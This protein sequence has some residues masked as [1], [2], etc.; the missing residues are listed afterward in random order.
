M[1]FKTQVLGRA[2]LTAKLDALVPNATKYAA[3]VK[4][5]IAETVADK[6]REVAPRGATL[7]Y[8][9]AIAGDFIKN[10]PAQKAIGIRD[11]K[12]PDAAGIFAPFQWNWLEFGT[13]PHNT[14]KG[15]G[16][17]A[18]QK[19]TRA[20]GAQIHPGTKAQPH[21]FF[22]WRAYKA[23]AKKRIN[24]AINKAVREAMGKK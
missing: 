11:T 4:Y 3:D 12:D 24:A 20:Q 17:K 1:A 10:R 19:Q 18:G 15:G 21:I 22:V 8:A 13:A 7:E 2:A 14:A 6:I 16:T 5:D 23:T 9:E